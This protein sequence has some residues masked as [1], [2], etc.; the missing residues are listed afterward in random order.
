MECSKRCVSFSLIS[1][2]FMVLVFASMGTAFLI[3]EIYRDSFSYWK[4][5]LIFIGIMC[6]AIILM[7]V[8]FYMTKFISKSRREEF[9]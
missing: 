4:L 5:S 1:A 3:I 9:Y 8:S 6:V 7:F 2:F